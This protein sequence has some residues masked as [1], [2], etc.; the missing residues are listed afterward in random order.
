MN[1]VARKE[2]PPVDCTFP[3]LT[4]RLSAYPK[5]KPTSPQLEEIFATLQSEQIKL[6]AKGAV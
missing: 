4:K 3:D 5:V 6:M 1:A 2:P